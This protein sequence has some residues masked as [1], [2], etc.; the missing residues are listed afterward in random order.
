MGPCWI[1]CTHSRQMHT[2]SQSRYSV[3]STH[4]HT[5]THTHTSKLTLLPS[6]SYAYGSQTQ[7]TVALAQLGSLHARATKYDDIIMRAQAQYVCAGL[8]LYSHTTQ[9][10]AMVV[11]S[12][13]SFI[14]LSTRTLKRM[15][16]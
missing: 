13:S 5:H 16:A 1:S 14:I 11:P 15:H 3:P 4:T 8:G 6:A 12:G 2:C 7:P 10:T 9:C